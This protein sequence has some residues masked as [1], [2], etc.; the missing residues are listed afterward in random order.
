MNRQLR[1]FS[2]G[3]VNPDWIED[4]S[5][6]NYIISHSLRLYKRNRLQFLNYIHKLK[7]PISETGA[8]SLINLSSCSPFQIQA[9]YNR[10]LKIEQ[11]ELE[12]CEAS[13]NLLNWRSE[14]KI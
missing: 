7:I 2:G 1:I 8:G 3:L 9:L 11:F 5:M 14:K 13:G 10:L 12:E 4:S 6:E